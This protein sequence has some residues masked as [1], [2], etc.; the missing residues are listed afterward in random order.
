TMLHLR[1]ACALGAA[2]AQ[3]GRREAMLVAAERDARRLA[4]E[5]VPWAEALGQLV[6]ATLAQQRGQREQAATRLVAATS[7]FEQADMTLHAAVAQH[8]CGQLVGGDAGRNMIAAA[9]NVLAGQRI[10]RP[11]RIVATIAPGFPD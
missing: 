7:G 10:R 1:C 5:G 8:R 3:P 2:A 11:D 9:A 4:R 6:L